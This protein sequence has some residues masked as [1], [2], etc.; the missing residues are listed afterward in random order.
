MPESYIPKVNV[1]KELSEISKDFTNP[2]EL[3]RETIANS[4]DA[5]ASM[6]RIEAFKDDLS[7]Q[8]ELVNPVTDDGVGMTRKELEVFFDLGFSNKRNRETAI[9]YKGRGTKITYNSSRVAVAT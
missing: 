4:V 9:G 3:I 2:Q 6:I 7:G 1:A 5:A 8:D